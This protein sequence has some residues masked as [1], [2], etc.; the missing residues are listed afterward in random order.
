M[1][2]RHLSVALIFTI[3]QLSAVERPGPESA[4]PH[5]ISFFFKPA[6]RIST[7]PTTEELLQVI[8]NPGP[9]HHRLIYQKNTARYTSGIFV[10]YEGRVTY[11]DAD[12]KVILPRLT[13]DETITVIVTERITPVIKHGN[14]VSYFQLKDAYPA[15]FYQFSRMKKAGKMVWKVSRD[16]TTTL[17][18]PTNAIIIL[19]LPTALTINEGIFPAT[20]GPNLIL[21]SIFVNS[22]IPTQDSAIAEITLSRFFAPLTSWFATSG[23]R[24]AY[25]AT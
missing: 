12:G 11:S 20:P 3:M 4:S 13:A 6:A 25:A 24:Y 19:A 9:L 21:P 14:T 15:S 18:V 7:E 2:L 16:E 5:A 23:E 1:I 22:V 10:L 8:S 17:H